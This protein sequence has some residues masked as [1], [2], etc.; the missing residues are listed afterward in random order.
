MHQY[1]QTYS[2]FTW[3]QKK[4]TEKFSMLITIGHEEKEYHV[5]IITIWHTYV[6]LGVG[7]K[8]ILLHGK[9]SLFSHYHFN[10]ENRY[11]SPNI[12]IKY[13]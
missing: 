9:I 13:F 8:N 6:F 12:H 2:L 3:L 5:A 1:G 7:S 11:T 10:V 4:K